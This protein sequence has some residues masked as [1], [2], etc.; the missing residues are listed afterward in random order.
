MCMCLEL[1][2]LMARLSVLKYLSLSSISTTF[3][4]VMIEPF[5]SFT[6]LKVPREVTN[7]INQLYGSFNYSAM[8]FKA[9]ENLQ[10]CNVM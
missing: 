1:E 10:N 5:I 7:N 2:S 6:D 4:R 3:L 9:I 8:A